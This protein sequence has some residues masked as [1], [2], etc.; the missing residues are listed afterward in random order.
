MEKHNNR[1]FYSLSNFFKDEFKD[2]VFKVSLD[3]G[4]TCPNRDGKISYGGCIFCSDSGS[5]E[6]TGDRIKSIT[7]QI[8]DQLQFM[9]E[10]IKGKKVIAYFQNFT[11]TYGSVEQLKKIYYEALNHP[12]VLGLAIGTRPDCIPEDVLDL[13]DEI[14]KKYFIW[15]ELGLQT[16]D[17]NIAKLI[18]RGYN[19]TV[20]EET[21]R[22][23]KR[24]NIKFVTHMIVGLPTEEKEA[25]LE[26]AKV[27][28]KSKAWGI[29][30]HSLHIIKGTHLE[31]LYKETR[32][33][34]FN[35]EEYVDIVTTIL[36]FI[37]TEMVV[38][39]VT[40]DGKKDEVIEP[41]WSLNKRKVL[42]EIEKELKKRENI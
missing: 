5:G 37:P 42:N 32:F 36:K 33:K 16:A 3:G 4:F 9:K 30:I 29:K 21:A 10:K 24:K 18:N 23:L 20:Y 35:L 26:T 28:V 17:D 6:F 11:N 38:H 31:K 14:N 13:L 25:I 2:K 12:M 22:S 34:I 19:L 8:D 39:R 40:G 27:I 7:E 15:I 41:V 1:R